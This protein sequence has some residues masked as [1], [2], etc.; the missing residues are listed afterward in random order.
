MRTRKRHRRHCENH[1]Q[2]EELVYLPQVLVDYNVAAIPTRDTLPYG[3]Q[4][5]WNGQNL[6]SLGNIASSAYAFVIDSGVLNTTGDLNLNTQWSR[7]WILGQ[8][9]F[10]DGNGHGT[11]VAGTI[12]ALA[13]NSGIVGV[14]PGAQIVSLK[15]FNNTGSAT[16]SSIIDAV[17]YAADV[18]ITN[19]LDLSKVVINMSLGGVLDST[20]NAAILRAAD[21]G[22][23]FTIAAGNS[24]VDADTTSPASVGTHPNVY[25]VSA[26]DSTGTMPAWSNWD[27]VTPTDPLDTVD[28]A[29]PGVSVM[30]YYKSGLLAYLSGTSMAAPHVA[31]LLLMGEVTSTRMA[32]PYYAGTAD[33]LAILSNLP[34]V[35]NQTLW[36]TEA[37]DS[38]IGGPGN[39]IVSGVSLT[40]S[41]S[42]QVDILIGSTGAD[43]FIL[44]DSRGAFY[45]DGIDGTLGTNDYALIQDFQSG[46]D[47][48]QLL[49]GNYFTTR[50]GSSLN[51]Y[52][53]RNANGRFETILSNS[54]ELV[55]VIQNSSISSGD[56][57][58]I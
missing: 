38:I 7:S 2:A 28:Y 17:N 32:T 22:I 13:N 1:R 48:L 5:V 19:R 42:G 44:A 11:H 23:R 16:L 56:V 49:A 45:N 35:A 51:I 46:V 57:I 29:A 9:P 52:W 8:S 58:Y 12:G 21:L 10:V 25:T 37:N 39:D 3:T 41:T 43:T 14:A 15:V 31:G 20:L 18:I 40:G 33:P 34:T 27:T 24:G 55:A 50:V 6:S 36:G 26:V 53:D 54:D 4:A 47:K 30:S